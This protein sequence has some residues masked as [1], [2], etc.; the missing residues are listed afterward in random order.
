M[1]PVA[2]VVRLEDLKPCSW[3]KGVLPD[4]LMQ[5]IDAKWHGSSARRISSHS[6]DRKTPAVSPSAHL[7]PSTPGTRARPSSIELVGSLPSGGFLLTNGRLTTKS[8]TKC[9]C[10]HHGL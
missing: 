2:V 8:C 4:A 1:T 6:V 10:D 3:V 7:E 9:G 5:V